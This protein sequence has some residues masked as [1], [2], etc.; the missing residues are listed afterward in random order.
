MLLITYAHSTIREV[1]LIPNKHWG[2]DGLLGCVFGRVQKS[3]F[4]VCSLIYISVLACCIGYPHNPMTARQVR[5]Q[6]NF[7][8]NTK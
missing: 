4:L 7:K 3:F 8:T 6:L 1:V 2:G 5:C